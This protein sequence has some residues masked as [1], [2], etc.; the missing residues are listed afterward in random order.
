MG[1]RHNLRLSDVPDELVE[2]LV[3]VLIAIVGILVREFI[4]KM[5]KK[6]SQPSKQDK[7]K[8]AEGREKVS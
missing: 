7:N 3:G 5:F 6:K 1:S 4:N 8:V 2:T